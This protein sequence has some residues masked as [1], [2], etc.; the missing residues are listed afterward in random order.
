MLKGYK[1]RLHPTAE[2]ADFLVRTIGCARLVQA[3]VPVPR[4]GG[5]PRARQREASPRRGVREVLR[6]DGRLPGV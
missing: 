1:Y 3:P 2:Q 5:Q 4:R 6:R